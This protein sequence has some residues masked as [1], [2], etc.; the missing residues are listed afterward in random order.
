MSVFNP[1]YRRPIVEAAGGLMEWC[2]TEDSSIDKATLEA[3]I[4]VEVRQLQDDLLQHENRFVLSTDI[5]AVLRAI[6]RQQ[7]G[8]DR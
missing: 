6:R 7:K 2:R 3:E 1:R 8:A 5:A 4:E